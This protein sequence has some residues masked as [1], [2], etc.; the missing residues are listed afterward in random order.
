MPSSERADD[1]RVVGLI[2]RVGTG[3]PGT[4]RAQEI[5]GAIATFTAAGKPAV[6]YAETFGELQSGSLAGV[7]IASAVR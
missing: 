4:A 1:N 3:S 7:L 5:A 2:A 6:A